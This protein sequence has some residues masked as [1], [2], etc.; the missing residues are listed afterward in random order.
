MIGR[1]SVLCSRDKPPHD[2]LENE[3]EGL[4]EEELENTG[5]LGRQLASYV[6]RAMEDFEYNKNKTVASKNRDK[7]PRAPCE[8][9]ETVLVRAGEETEAK[10]CCEVA[11]V[12]RLNLRNCALD[13]KDIISP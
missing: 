7:K 10:I 5:L 6:S 1:W 11:P 8:H 3:A 4:R 2:P 13:A 12:S 9:F